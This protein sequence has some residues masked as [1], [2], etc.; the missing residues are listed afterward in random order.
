MTENPN[1]TRLRQCYADWDT[2]HGANPEVWSA[3]LAEDCTLSSPG[4]G[5][6]GP[7]LPVIG[8]CRA[9]AIS[10]L[11]DFTKD[12]EMEY[13]RIDEYICD[14]DRVVAIGSTAW[15]NKATGKR[16]ESPKV[17]IWSFRDG[18]AVSISEYYDTASLLEAA[19]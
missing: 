19:A 1:V 16:C 15:K 5:R 13:Y 2:S 17:D 4:A 3:I 12:W 11:S 18:K 8:R 7:E 10:Y 14:G 6:T 9:D